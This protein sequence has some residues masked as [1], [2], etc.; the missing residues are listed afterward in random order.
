M[1]KP[2]TIG[3]NHVLGVYKALKTLLDKSSIQSYSEPIRAT[4]YFIRDEYPNIASV[5]NKYEEEQ[6]DAHSDLQIKLVDG[7]EIN[8]NLFCV[9]GNSAIQPKN[10]GAKSFLKKYFQ[11][12]EIQNDF[13]L[14]IEKEY[15]R[16]L[17]G[18]M[19]LKG[20]SKAP[21]SISLLKKKVATNYPKFN[22]KINPFRR[23]FLFNLR[24]SCFDLLKDEYNVGAKGIQHAFTE[25]MMMNH[26]TIITR[27]TNK[28]K[29]LSVEYWK[30]NINS[31]NGVKI[32]KK[33]ND[34][35]GIRSGNEALTLRFKFES[36]PTSSIKIATSYEVFPEESVT[37]QK[38]LK[39]IHRFEQ[40][41][42]EHKCSGEKKARPNAIGKCNEAMI[43]YRII[44][45]NPMIDQ[46]N[47]NAYYDMLMAYYTLATPEELTNIHNASIL[48]TQTIYRYLS[49][50]YGEYAI[51]AIQLV[52][53]SYIK[54]RADTSDLQLILIVK[55]K[56][57][58]ESLS[59]KATAKRNT[60]ITKK[61][62]GAGQLLGPRY[63]DVGSLENLINESKNKFNEKLLDHRQVLEIIS[64]EIGK[65]LSNA[66]QEKLQRGLKVLL[67]DKIVVLTI[68]TDNEC[69][70]LEPREIKGKVEVYPLSPTAIQTTL[71]WNHQQEELSMRVKFSASQKK[72]WSS[73]KLACEH[74]VT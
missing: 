2:S 37:I 63:F 65:V 17:Q 18:I 53:D 71:R 36:S 21:D 51:E 45:E 33:G 20:K 57:I 70:L 32:Y 41:I 43:Y 59:L 27:Y 66:S 52:G 28:N 35:V 12:N 15:E 49:Q 39:S 24:E 73:L 64:N 42:E 14:F 11:S 31:R 46:I 3:K 34:T 38:N 54:N 50:K 48:T 60:N 67:D 6:P 72:G 8:I 26:T 25:L 9:K 16:F 56:Y 7:Q 44:K 5:S 55:G 62:P 69:L 58:T 74:R 29:C 61:N 30:S 22:E 23:I 19:S 47:E 4:A 1:Q 13:N 68:Y 40:L 10:L